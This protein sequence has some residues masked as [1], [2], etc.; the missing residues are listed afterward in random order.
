MNFFLKI[1][2]LTSITVFFLK[3]DDIELSGT[4][5]DFHSS[6]PDFELYDTYGNWNFAGLDKGIVKEQLGND[7]KPVFNGKT[8]ST[9]TEANFNQWYN[10]TSGGNQ[11]M[12][13]TITLQKVGNV[14]IYD[15][16]T[17]PLGETQNVTKKGFFPLDNQL[18]GNEQNE[19]N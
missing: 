7:K 9:T 8:K 15:S 4:L 3:A 12:P 14:Y 19:H 16:N 5:R 1:I 2:I 11:S 6:H 10:N 17:N 18:F 13:Y